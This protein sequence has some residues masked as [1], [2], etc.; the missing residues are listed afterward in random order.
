MRRV[1][2]KLRSLL[3]LHKNLEGP[4]TPPPTR[5]APPSDSVDLTPWDHPFLTPLNIRRFREYSDAVWSIAL[6]HARR[7]ARP[8]RIACAVNMAQ[9]SYNYCRLLNEAGVASDL[10]PHP[11]DRTALNCPE[12]EEYDGDWANIFDGAGFLQSQPQLTTP[13]PV[14]RLPMDCQG[15][16]YACLKFKLGERADLLRL[17]RSLPSLRIEALLH[18][19]ALFPYTTWARA[20]AG[21]DATL[22]AASP[23]AAYLCGRPYCIFTAGGDL[24][25]DCGRRDD[26]GAI[27]GLAFNAASWIFLSNPHPLAHCR[28]LGLTNGVYLPYA[29]DDHRYCPGEGQARHAWEAQ[30]GKG[31]YILSTA[32]IDTSVKGNGEAILDHLTSIARLRPQARFVF[33]TWGNH[34]DQFRAVIDRAGLGSQFIFLPP[35]GKKR[36]IDY[37]RSCDVT[38]DQFVFGYYGATGLEAAACGKPLV[39]RLRDAHY[40]P[41]YQ[42]DV[43][44][45]ENVRQPEELVPALLG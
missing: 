16:D 14:V 40:E 23:I 19:V 5:I 30:Y 6:D 13:V 4:V 28:R 17:M 24:M 21:Y 12:W 18:H 39:M 1:L 20:L 7:C 35:V 41:L 2:R 42:G 10:Y 33:L 38:L 22:V 32:R 9:T 36:L 43:A 34:A 31:V 26:Y 27:T 37:Y 8:L 25:F 3:H 11:L 15:T 44:P 29:T 45:V